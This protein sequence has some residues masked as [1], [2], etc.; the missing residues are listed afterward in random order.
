MILKDNR[1]SRCRLVDA[2][3]V[4]VFVG[5]FAEPLAE[6]C[7]GFGGGVGTEVIPDLLEDEEEGGGV[8][9]EAAGEGVRDEIERKDE[10]AES[11]QDHEPILE[12][13]LLI[14]SGI[15]E[16]EHT[17][18][19]LDAGLLRHLLDLLE[20]GSGVIEVSILLKIIFE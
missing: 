1:F 14:E 3:D 5:D 15:I 20:E 12:R 18:D 4:E 16:D 10:V 6:A 9:G 13:K 17:I 19:G 2:G 8:V 11:C 7:A